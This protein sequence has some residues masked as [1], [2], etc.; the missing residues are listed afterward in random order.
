MKLKILLG[1]ILFI[2]LMTHRQDA[3]PLKLLNDQVAAFNEQ[4]I[5]KL[6]ENVSE[7]FKYFYLTSDELLLEVSGKEKFRKSMEAYFGSGRKVLSTIDDYTIDGNRIS[8]KE[9]VSH[10]NNSGERVYSSAL[11]IYEVKNDK[12]TRSWYFID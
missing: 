2:S 8:F 12:I 9:T 5:D 3:K 7:D 10:L 1:T 6:V 4:D 11:G